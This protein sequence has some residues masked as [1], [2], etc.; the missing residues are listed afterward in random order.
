MDNFKNAD[1]PTEDD[2]PDLP[3]EYAVKRIL[4]L[5]NEMEMHDLP[6]CVGVLEITKMM[7]FQN[8]A[9]DA[10]GEEWKGD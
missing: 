6:T 10:E 8:H 1:H 4:D 7:L 9:L 3:D 2:R 5:F